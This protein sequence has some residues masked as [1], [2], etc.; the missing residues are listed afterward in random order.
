[1]VKQNLNLNADIIRISKRF[2]LLHIKHV[3]LYGTFDDYVSELSYSILKNIS[4]Y[5]EDRGSFSTWCYKVLGTKIIRDIVKKIR[6]NNIYEIKSLDEDINDEG[7]CLANIISDS[8]DYRE[9]IERKLIV[10]ELFL[11]I[12]PLI[13]EDF[14]T[15]AIG[16]KTITEMAHEKNI[17]KQNMFNKIHRE[18]IR[19]RNMFQDNELELLR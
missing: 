17:S 18:K 9:D 11:K 5:D 7:D 10:K 4:S 3:D 16:G 19:L 2:A 1:M 14:K 13:S 15:Y 8:I 12:I 6:K